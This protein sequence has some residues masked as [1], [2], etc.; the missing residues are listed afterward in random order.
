MRIKTHFV[1]PPIPKR[2]FDWQAWD[3]DNYDGAPDS[4]CPMGH[5]E[6]EKEA[7][8]DLMDQIV[9]RLESQIERLHQRIEAIADPHHD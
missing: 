6:T 7:I 5:G 2:G 4:C 8:A 9:D 1:N 3:D